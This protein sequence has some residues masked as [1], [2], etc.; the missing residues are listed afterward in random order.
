MLASSNTRRLRAMRL[1]GVSPPFFSVAVPIFEIQENL[2]KKGPVLDHPVSYWCLSLPSRE[3]GVPTDT[4]RPPDRAGK[5][6]VSTVPAMA[7]RTPP[8]RRERIDR[9]ERPVKVSRG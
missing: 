7:L 9:R 5:D 2:V 4:W 3:K 6:L 8:Q 1:D